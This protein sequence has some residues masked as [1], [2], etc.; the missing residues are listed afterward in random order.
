[1]E[2]YGTDE[3]RAVKSVVTAVAKKLVLIKKL[4]EVKTENN[5]A[6]KK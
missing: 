4:A 5:M 2:I 6:M 1:M 3:K